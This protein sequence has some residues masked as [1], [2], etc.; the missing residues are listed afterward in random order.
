VPLHFLDAN[1]Q[2]A[3]RRIADAQNGMTENRTHH[4]ELNQVLGVAFKIGAKVQNHAFA[5]L[6]RKQARDG[7]TVDPR[8]RFQHELCHG[9]KRAGISRRHDAR[10]LALRD[11]VDG[12]A[13][14]RRPPLPERQRRLQFVRNDIRRVA[15]LAYVLERRITRDQRLEARFVA[16]EKIRNFRVTLARQRC[17]R[18]DDLGPAI[19]AH[20]VQGDDGFIGYRHGTPILG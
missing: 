1:V 18:H 14:A 20:R 10:R 8:Q 7:G 13:H 17:A 4:G 2:Q 19:A 16:D 6:R 11:G 5:D 12:K 9:H 3:D 15:Y